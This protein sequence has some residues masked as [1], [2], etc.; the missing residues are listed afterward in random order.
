MSWLFRFSSL[1]LKWLVFISRTEERYPNGNPRPPLQLPRLSGQHGLKQ[2]KELALDDQPHQD[3]ELCFK[4][5]LA[6]GVLVHSLR[7]AGSDRH[8]QTSLVPKQ[9]RL[10]LRKEDS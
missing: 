1:R 4:V 3:S 6:K 9:R 5:V 2:Q 8:R 7:C 10:F